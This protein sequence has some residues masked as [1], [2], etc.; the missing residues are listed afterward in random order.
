MPFEL[1]CMRDESSGITIR[2]YN[3]VNFC[4]SLIG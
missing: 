4:S 3:T 1:I 2:F